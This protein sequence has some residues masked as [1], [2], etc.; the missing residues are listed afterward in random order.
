MSN[1]GVDDL[2][3]AMRRVRADAQLSD[4]R[5]LMWI[6]MDPNSTSWVLFHTVD[7]DVRAKLDELATQQEQLRSMVAHMWK[8][9]SGNW[10]DDTDLW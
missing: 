3:L 1:E 4:G 2:T 9:A 7:P 8:D 5:S 10:H 6:D